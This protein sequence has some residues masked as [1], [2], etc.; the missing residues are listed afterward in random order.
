MLQSIVENIGHNL[1][2]PLLLFFYA[3]FLIPLLKV[4]FEYPKALY[5]ALTIVLLLGIG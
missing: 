3:G 5:Q 1:F 2:K 4:E